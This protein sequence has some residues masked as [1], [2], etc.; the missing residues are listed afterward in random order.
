M[1]VLR[2]GEKKG[3]EVR[4]RALINSC[5]Q[6]IQRTRRGTHRDTRKRQRQRASKS[7]KE[8]SR[9]SITVEDGM[10]FMIGKLD[11]EKLMLGSSVS[12]R[13]G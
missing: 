7:A 3:D 6:D 12:E 1:L 10:A 4:L 8:H 11:K 13:D 2:S 5:K 9:H